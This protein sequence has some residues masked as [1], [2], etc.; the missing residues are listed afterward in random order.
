[1]WDYHGGFGLFNDGSNGLFDFDLN[2]PL[3][4]ALGFNVPQ[5]ANYEKKPLE[6][7]YFW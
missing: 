4:K 6:N 5:Q 7:H 3:V 1:M 2:I